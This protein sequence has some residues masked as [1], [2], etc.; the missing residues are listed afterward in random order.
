MEN[1][2]KHSKEQRVKRENIQVHYELNW[3]QKIKKKI[4][5]QLKC[6]HIHIIIVHSKTI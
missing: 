5:L 2:R 4:N 6:L 1:E 3:L